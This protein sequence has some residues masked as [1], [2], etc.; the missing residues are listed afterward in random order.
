[1]HRR[2]HSGAGAHVGR[3]AELAEW[4]LQ[5]LRLEFAELIDLQVDIEETG[6]TTGEVDILLEGMEAKGS[7]ED[8]VLP[9]VERDHVVTRAGDVWELGPHR[10]SCGDARDKQSYEAVLDRRKANIVFTDPPYNVPI[11]GH[12]SGLG[13]VKH[14]EFV[15][16]SGELSSAQFTTL[17]GV[18]FEHLINYSRK[19]SIHYI[20]MDWRH[21][22]E[23]LNATT[24]LYELKNICVW[25]KDN[26][27]MGAFYRSKH[28]LVL[29]LQ[30]GTGP[31]Q[32]NVSLGSTGRYRTNVWDYPGM[33]SLGEDAPNPWPCTPQ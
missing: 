20:C 4:D 10:L 25:N 24:S 15:M 2:T 29:V 6:F 14:R 18:V 31:F 1:L 21:L 23:I 13:R 32:N 33:N 17:L 27:G 22:R 30:N 19:G 3:L 26:A 11:E 16:A 12:V 7:P 8:N 5:I 9:A 28:E